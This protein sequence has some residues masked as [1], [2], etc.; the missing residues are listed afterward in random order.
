MPGVEGSAGLSIPASHVG[1]LLVDMLQ[2][3]RR[4]LKRIEKTYCF[5]KSALKASDGEMVETMLLCD[6]GD[7]AEDK[8]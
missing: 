7:M 8:S 5:W 6:R 3:V 4:A 2:D 1:T